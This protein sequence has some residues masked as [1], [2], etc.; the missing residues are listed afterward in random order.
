MFAFLVNNLCTRN[1]TELTVFFTLSSCTFVLSLM[2]SCSAMEEFHAKNTSARNRSI[3]YHHGEIAKYP[4][5]SKSRRSGQSLW[6]IFHLCRECVFLDQINKLPS[7][8]YLLARPMS[9]MN[10]ICYFSPL[11]IKRLSGL[12]SLCKKCLVWR[13]RILSSS[14]SP[15]I[16]TVLTEN[17]LLRSTNKSSVL[18]ESK[19]IIIRLYPASEPTAY[20][21]ILCWLLEGNLQFYHLG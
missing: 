17:R 14:C 9:T 5:G 20:T 21:F 3:Q 18:F 11:P 4:C 7:F 16:R 19:S 1:P 10:M 15:S 2:P 12:I 6:V 8:M 13:Y